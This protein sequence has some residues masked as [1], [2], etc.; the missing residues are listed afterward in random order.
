MKTIAEKLGKELEWV[1]MPFDSLIPALL[2]QKIDIVA[3][4]M[5]ATPERRN[6]SLSLLPMKYHECFHCQR[7]Y[8]VK[9]AG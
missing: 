8:S 1:D 2:A 6:E 4:G 5:S 7:Q 9:I 3:A